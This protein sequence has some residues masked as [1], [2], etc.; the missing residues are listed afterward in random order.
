[1]TSAKVPHLYHPEKHKS[2]Q[3]KPEQAA[4]SPKATFALEIEILQAGLDIC[5]CGD[6][7][8]WMKLLCNYTLELV[9]FTL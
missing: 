5:I 7:R 6:A 2:P 9:D 4:E 8:A 1:L 3:V